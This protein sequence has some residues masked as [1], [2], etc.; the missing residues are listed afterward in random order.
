MIKVLVTG[1]NG[2]LGK[3]FKAVS[4]NFPEIKF[5]FFD[6]EQCD[7]TNFKSLS[8]IVFNYDIEIIINCAAYTSVDNA[9]NDK[10]NA[11]KVNCLGVKNL[12]KII[13]FNNLKLIHFSTDY[14]F[15][16]FGK[17]SYKENDSINPLSYY[18]KSKAEGE[19]I[20]L[21]SKAEAI[22]V[23]TSWLFGCYGNNFVKKIINLSKSIERIELVKDQFIKPTCSI[24]LAKTV[25][26]LILFPDSF[27][28]KIYHFSNNGVISCYD[29]AKFF[30][31][32]IE[33]KLEI[34]P[35]SMN[36]YKPEAIR[37]KNA[38]LNTELIERTLNLKI[39]NWNERID[40]CLKI[41]DEK[42]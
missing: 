10:K 11:L 36:E 22:I 42:K 14:V 37:P 21:E 23:R 26:K 31:N 25:I 29:F 28:N 16:G 17:K 15:D 19:K 35:I 33:S 1:S 4:I 41:L 9:E 8:S 39:R 2:Q 38:I 24:D 27:K 7:I 32:K 5:Y 20:I 18:G 30:M 13:Q 34:Y 12:I 40:K 6:H 3:S